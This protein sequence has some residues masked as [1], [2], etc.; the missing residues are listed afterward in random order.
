MFDLDEGHEDKITRQAVAWDDLTLF[1]GG[2]G[3]ILMEWDIPSRCLLRK[4]CSRY[5]GY[6]INEMVMSL[7]D[8]FLFTVGQEPTIQKICLE[9]AD[10]VSNANI[11]FEGTCSAMSIGKTGSH[12]YIATSDKK[13]HKYSIALND[14]VVSYNSEHKHTILKV[15]QPY[16][17]L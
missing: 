8:K 7:D 1:S 6:F 4:Y 3:G 15:I 13:I 14:V 11:K 2:S 17:G 16:V 12:L 9:H 10:L 5:D